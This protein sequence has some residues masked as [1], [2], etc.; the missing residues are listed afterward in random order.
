MPA[1]MYIFPFYHVD[2][3]VVVVIMDPETPVNEADRQNVSL[4]CEVDAGNP[5]ILTAVR[6]YLDGDLLKELPDCSRN[7]TTTSSE[8]SLAFCDIDPSKLLLESVGRTF[9]GNY[10]CEGKNEAGWGPISPSTSVIV[11]CKSSL[12][13]VTRV[14]RWWE[15]NREN[16]YYISSHNMLCP[17]HTCFE[18]HYIFQWQIIYRTFRILIFY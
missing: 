1:R 15:R 4:T 7:S 17:L 5:A 13:H 16:A 9:H 18:F 14:M 12:S 11:Y 6:W 2:K 10:S 3:P 8:E